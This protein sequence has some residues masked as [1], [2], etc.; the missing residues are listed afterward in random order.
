VEERHARGRLARLEVPALSHEALG[1]LVR[2]AAGPSV[3]ESAA[4]SAARA[5]DG[6]PFLAEVLGRALGAGATDSADASRVLGDLVAKCD[7]AQR[8]LLS[9][10]VATDEWTSIE[11]LAALAAD[12]VGAV[13]ERVLALERAGL[14]RRARAEAGG[15]A[16]ALSHHAVHAACSEATSA[17]DRVR[18]HEALLAHLPL[19]A[20]PPE[21]RVRH[22]LGAER[23]VEAARVARQ[24]GALAESRRAYSLAADMFEIAAR[25]VTPDRDL[26]LGSRGRALERAGRYLEAAAVWGDLARRA[27]PAEAE[28][29]G[30][31]EAHALIAANRSREGLDR[32]DAARASAGDRASVATGLT[33]LRTLVTF[34]IGPLPRA[35]QRTRRASASRVVDGKRDAKIGVLLSFLEPLTG[36]RYL[37]RARDEFIAAGAREQVALV[38]YYFAVLA[39]VGSRSVTSPALAERWARSAHARVEA[40][41][42]CPE[43]RGMPHFLAGLAALRRGAWT[44]SKAS[45]GRAGAAFEHA[46]GTTERM[47][48]A[49]WAMMSDAYAQDLPAM[50]ADIAWF[51][52]R[53]S[54]AGEMIIITHVELLKAYAH[55]LDGRFDDAV[56]ATERRAAMFGE[57]R[58][59]AQRAAALLYRHLPAIY[60][61]DGHVARRAFT[62]ALAAS[63]RHRFFGTL[64]AGPFAGI[65]ALLEANALRTGDRDASARR[66]EK[67]ARILDA[68]PPLMAGMSWR[69]RAYSADAAGRAALALQ[70]LERAEQEARRFGRSIDVA[71]ARFQRGLRVGGETGASWMSEARAMLRPLGASEALLREDARLR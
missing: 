13:L 22:L 25:E 58:P 16:I 14:V 12:T 2:R 70:H 57:E 51:D 23:I 65:G 18:V 6:R 40:E 69:A 17:S 62:S 46:D 39:H 20:T 49:S 34:A 30:H 27:T 66:V 1:D 29:L 53:L 42:A 47:M 36:L 54:G 68:A 43:V 32:L 61:T 4:R 21:R 71:I 48:A 56:A 45:L 10:L 26:L 41:H 31:H 59:N 35:W 33:A 19:D 9:Q 44:E 52:Q 8:A 60:S 38:E 37:Q 28:D 63:R 55:V 67:L 7:V 11:V 50:K 3:S 24:A 15:I 5:C 64:F